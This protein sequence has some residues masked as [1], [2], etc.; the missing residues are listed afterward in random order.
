MMGTV[1]GLHGTGGPMGCQP[2]RRFAHPRIEVSQ[3]R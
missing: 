1:N 3:A 2:L